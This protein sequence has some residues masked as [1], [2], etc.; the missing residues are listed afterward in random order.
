MR[1]WIIVVASI[2]ITD[3]WDIALMVKASSTSETS[4]FVFETKRQIIP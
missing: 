4:V 2:T 1:F 3:F